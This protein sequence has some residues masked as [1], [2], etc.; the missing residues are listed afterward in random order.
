MLITNKQ[1]RRHN[2]HNKQLN[3]RSTLHDQDLQQ[4][5]EHKVIGVI[6]D[7]NL[8]WRGHV[9]G[10]YTKLSRTLL[11]LCRASNSFYPSCQG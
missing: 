10:V 8:Q 3:I 4:V 1:Q 6:V 5:K 9:N 11:A 7:I 2:L